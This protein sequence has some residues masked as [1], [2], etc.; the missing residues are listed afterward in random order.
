MKKILLSLV[1]LATLSGCAL[2]GVGKTVLLLPEA[3]AQLENYLPAD[4][5]STVDSEFKLVDDAMA[6]FDALV[7]GDIDITYVDAATAIFGSVE[8]AKALEVA[9]A[10]IE[11]VVKDYALASDIDVPVLVR[12][13]WGDTKSFYKTARDNPNA[14]KAAQFISDVGPLALYAIK[15]VALKTA[16]GGLL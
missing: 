1:M 10:T 13:T 5:R 4:V 14:V 15:R 16:T 2:L 9:T 3:R 6:K 7:Q 8:K 11:Q 12:T